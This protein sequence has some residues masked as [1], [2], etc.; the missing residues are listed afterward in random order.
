AR[1]LTSTLGHEAT[2]EEIADLL[3]KPIEDVSKMLQLSQRTALLSEI[4]T[5]EDDGDVLDRLVN[6]QSQDPL[7]IV[8]EEKMFGN[9]KSLF[10]QAGLTEKQV[11]VVSMRFGLNGYNEHTLEEVGNDIGLTRERVRQIQ[12]ESLKRLRSYMDRQGLSLEEL[13]P[14]EPNKDLTSVAPR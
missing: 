4:S 2:E 7:D 3:D 11:N 13:L 1:E 6:G 10:K 14:S 8:A 9:V 12:V 5:S